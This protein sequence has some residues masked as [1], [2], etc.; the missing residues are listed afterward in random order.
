V[1]VAIIGAGVGGLAC[2][3][4]LSRQRHD[5]TVFER[6]GSITEIGAGLTLSSNALRVFDHLGL[7]DALDVVAESPGDGLYLHYQTAALLHSVDRSGSYAATGKAGF[8]QVHRSDLLDVLL[9]AVRAERNCCV[10]TGRNLVDIEQTPTRVTARFEAGVEADFDIVIGCDGLRS[11]VRAKLVGAGSPRFTGQVAFRCLVDASAAAPH[12]SAGTSAMFI[13]PGAFFNRYYVR[14]RAL[15]NCVGIA[16]ADSWREEGWTLPSSV[17]E[18]ESV[19]SGWHSDVVDLVRKV[20]PDQLF[21]WALYDR[22]PLRQSVGGRVA[23]LGDAAHPMLP[24]LA[25]G[26]A[27]AL[28]DAIILARCLAAH[29]EA[30]IALLAYQRSRIH[31][32]GQAILDSRRQAQLVQSNDPETYGQRVG[33]AELRAKYF[34][35][36]AAT[37]ELSSEPD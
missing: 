11:T 29:D 28:E 6:A 7:R 14:N 34:D 20:Q 37:V 8:F 22:K 1:K 10:E 27:F 12:M 26:A 24:F 23:L 17:E 35:Y 16:A 33:K 9:T 15:V 30:A 19:F 2:A 25:M 32:C 13:G 4:A 36:D 31:R 18:F 3:L 5:V 21:K